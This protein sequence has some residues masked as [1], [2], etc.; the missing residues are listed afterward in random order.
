MEITQ[1]YKIIEDAPFAFVSTEVTFDEQEKPVDAIYRFVNKSYKEY[2]GI[3]DEV[4]GKLASEILIGVQR[5]GFNY[6]AHFANV[7]KSQKPITLDQYSQSQNK[8]Y[9]I[10]CVPLDE[11]TLGSFIFDST[12][13]KA[14]SH[15]LD[16]NLE[17]LDLIARNITD[18][19]FITDTNGKISYVSPSVQSVLGETADDFIAGFYST[20]K[21]NPIYEYIKS[22]LQNEQNTTPYAGEPERSQVQMQSCYQRQDGQEIEIE[23]N[24]SF[25]R[26]SQNRLKGFLGVIVDINDTYIMAREL[27]QKNSYIESILDSIPDLMLIVDAEGNILDSPMGKHNLTSLYIEKLQAK[28]IYAISSPDLAK[29]IKA[30]I[31]KVL[32][33]GE[34][35]F[36]NYTLHKAGA[37]ISYEGRYSLHEGDKLIIMIRNTSRE[38]NALEALRQQNL[39]QNMMAKLSAAIVKASSQELEQ[40]IDELLVDI[41]HF[42]HAQKVYV[43]LF[44]A[45]SK[46]LHKSNGY[47]E[48]GVKELFQKG[49][50]IPVTLNPWLNKQI[51]NREVVYCP[52]IEELPEI[53]QAEKEMF[54]QGGSRSFI[55]I[56]IFSGSKVI[57]VLSFDGFHRSL[58]VSDS[59]I[60][61]LKVVAGILAE[62]FHK[63][64]I[65]NEVKQLM[66]MQ[67]LLSRMA[68]YYINLPSNMLDAAI[69]LSL[70]EMATFTKADRCYLFRYD[71]EQ[72]RTVLSYDWSKATMP[73][74][75]LPLRSIPLNELPTW[76]E[77]HRRGEYVFIKDSNL[78]E[79]DDTIRYLLVQQNIKSNI[80]LPLMA[81]KK[82]LGF[83]GFDWFTGSEPLSDREIPLLQLF[84]KLLVNAQSKVELEISLRRAKEKAEAANLAKDEFLA[85][86]S[87][88]IR[89]PL[90]GVIG[91]TELL[92]S[93][94]LN[95]TQHSYV[96]N[97]ISSSYNLL[98][99][100]NDIL[101][102]SKIE[103]GKMELDLVKTDIIE[104]VERAADIIK[105]KTSQIG[106]E[107]LLN[108]ALDMPRY[109]LIDPLR[110][111]QIL[112]NLLSNAAKFTK[113]GEIE[114]SL[115]YKMT[116][117]DKADITVSILD[118]GIG[119]EKA[120]QSELFKAFSQVDSS[121]TR[122]YGGT[123]L[124]LSISERLAN[125]MDSSIKLESEAGKGST[126][127]FSFNTQV[128]PDESQ[129]L[130]K[131]QKLKKIV[132]VDNNQRNLEILKSQL[133]YW[134]LETII[135]NGAMEA[136]HY[137]KDSRHS[138]ALLINANL[139]YLNGINA[140]KM[141]RTQFA[142]PHNQIPVI[143]LTDA[144]NDTLI[145]DGCR[146]YQAC[147]RLLKPVKRRSLLEVLSKVDNET[148]PQE[149]EETA[150][151]KAETERLNLQ[152]PPHI[153]IAEDNFLN[154]TLLKDMLLK[155]IPNAILREAENGIEAIKLFEEETP[156][157]ILM[158]VQMPE[159][160]G[161]SA[162]KKIR[163]SSK[164][165][166]IAVTAGAL[167][168]ERDKCLAAK[169]NDF[170]SKPLLLKELMQTL[171]KY[172]LGQV[173]LNGKALQ[174]DEHRL[175]YFNYDV[176]LD[177][178]SQDTE[179]LYSLLEIVNAT[180]P[181][182]L[183][184][185]QVA[186][187]SKNSKDIKSILHSIRGTAQ[188]M[189][190]DRLA[191][192]LRELELK[193]ETLGVNEIQSLHEE[194]L[195]QW[196]K[197]FAI[198]RDFKL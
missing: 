115:Q 19:I 133:E 52:D 29:D 39:F 80:S 89:S 55:S 4:I 137:L 151:K 188:N 136:V 195:H 26:D 102:F 144:S 49:Q 118:T 37:I 82:C 113:E 40:I 138:D 167:K 189:H 18:V 41:A 150:P 22:I 50:K 110:L 8:W 92:M 174:D 81:D 121:N 12:P 190:F 198:I 11:R 66:E 124:G 57:G 59:M 30:A 111:N 75:V 187:D 24:I 131:Y 171:K 183:A 116:S 96:Q 184:Q 16:E 164:V 192:V 182:K 74:L 36:V 95:Q 129:W 185:L 77:K 196:E 67:N 157:L 103:A 21:S 153:L 127:S 114:I 38:A 27:R 191:S 47:A 72:K 160:D 43:F 149:P 58:E 42:F 106:V 15:A 168:E 165:P 100:I 147:Y 54:R 3:T 85:N 51:L 14:A 17:K 88:E 32:S 104:L 197:V 178:I 145:M 98:T 45:E 135:F 181:E 93:S 125:M 79:A 10:H 162:S 56:P 68:T 13:L 73:P 87:H 9:Q 6:I 53:A 97:I 141:I 163:E 78:Y 158:D 69:K 175:L 7:C 130:P 134:K 123:G 44:D 83:V 46:Y 132:L 60:E 101:D 2:F 23:T 142:R 161:I 105:I 193:Y 179:T 128:Y 109:A 112:T 70:E 146:E 99:I 33:T 155:L 156:D 194:I 152:R 180:Y 1:L 177:N 86:M 20:Q 48:P 186:L 170:L 62:A 126:F 117:A 28:S 173:E 139:P 91:F 31:D 159:M 63:K 65:E 5:K 169:M 166:I 154:R 122:R 172:L 120:K 61:N 107:L 71:W 148:P 119:I 94:Q 176:L 143:L 76:V 108:I 35:A 34:V 84:S 90:H 64:E 140:I 25:L